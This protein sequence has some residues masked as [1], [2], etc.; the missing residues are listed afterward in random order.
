MCL[1]YIDFIAMLWRMKQTN[2]RTKILR[3]Y[4]YLKTCGIE[5][6]LDLNKLPK[7]QPLGRWQAKLAKIAADQLLFA[8]TYTAVFFVG[9]GLLNV[10]VDNYQHH[11]F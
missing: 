9:V 5:V 1:F 2:Q 3:S 8:T 11:K 4:A 6:L 10:A 7:A